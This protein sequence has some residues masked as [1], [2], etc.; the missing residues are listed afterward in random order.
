MIHPPDS[1]A[2]CEIRALDLEDPTNNKFEAVEVNVQDEWKGKWNIQQITYA[3]LKGTE[4]FTNKSFQK[5]A[6]NLAMTMWDIEINLDLKPVLVT[7]SPISRVHWL[8]GEE[9]PRFKEHPEILAVAWLPEQGA[10]SG[11]IYMND[12]HFW[13]MTGMGDIID[14]KF[15]VGYSALSV[16][17]HEIGH[18]L[19]LTH[20]TRK[21]WL[22]LLDPIYNRAIFL[23][24]PYD[25]ARMLLKY[26]EEIKASPWYNSRMRAW[27]RTRILRYRIK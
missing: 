2:C 16:L 18:M 13:N 12:D 5:Q 7:Q 19:G 23:P 4:D 25:V 6:V 22:D 21:L 3:V 17:G 20:S 11:T 15:K 1:A 27:L 10:I 8:T 24:S 26:P 14:G 9:Y